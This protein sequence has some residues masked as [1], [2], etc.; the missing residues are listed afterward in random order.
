MQFDTGTNSEMVLSALGEGKTRDEIKSTLMA[1][2]V[3]ERFAADLIKE[4]SK[5][6]RSKR[7]AKGLT[8]IA[9]GALIC[10]LSCV[11]SLFFFT[12]GSFAWTLYG[13]TSVGVLIVFAGL[14]KVF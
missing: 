10:F 14:I 1:A 5:L 4:V 7:A 2:G 9:I 12:Q 8:L 13:L 3:E 11:S 6:Y